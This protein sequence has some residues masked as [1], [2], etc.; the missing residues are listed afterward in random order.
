[1]VFIDTKTGRI[2]DS[3]RNVDCVA[4]L[5]RETYEEWEDYLWDD[6]ED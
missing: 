5:E 3:N 6:Q 2:L 4:V 1:M